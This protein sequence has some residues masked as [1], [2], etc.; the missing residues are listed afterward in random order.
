MFWDNQNIQRHF[1]STTGC[2]NNIFYLYPKTFLV[3]Y[4]SGLLVWNISE[5]L[6]ISGKSRFQFMKIEI[7]GSQSQTVHYRIPS[8][9]ISAYSAS[10]IS[11]EHVL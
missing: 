5:Q 6:S 7:P 3:L 11:F 9:Y 10:F 4:N 2:L 8:I 1:L